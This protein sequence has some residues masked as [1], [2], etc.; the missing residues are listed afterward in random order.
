METSVLAE[1]DL[2]YRLLLLRALE[3]LLALCT[4][5]LPCNHAIGGALPLRCEAKLPLR[6]RVDL[7]AT[8]RLGGVPRPGPR[9]SV[10]RSLTGGLAQQPSRVARLLALLFTLSLR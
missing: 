7:P 9:K 1:L 3:K 10:P 2:G 6:V 4:S 8:P 5:L